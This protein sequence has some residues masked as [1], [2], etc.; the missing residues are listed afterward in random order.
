MVLA[1]TLPLPLAAALLLQAGEFQA[2]V[3]GDPMV[4]TSGN[5]VGWQVVSIEDGRAAFRERG[6][7]RRDPGAVREH[8]AQVGPLYREHG[9]TAFEP[10]VKWMLL[11]PE[12][13][14]WDPTFYDAELAAFKANGLKWVPFLIAGPAYATP[15]WFKDSPESV[16]AVDLETGDVS[17]EQSIWNPRLR[18]R[19]RAWLE[20]FFAHYG[21]E[22]MQAVLLGI[23]GVFGESIYTAGGNA[24]TTIW[25]GDYPQHT[26]WWCGDRYAEADFRRAMRERYESVAALNQAWGTQLTTFDEVRPFA[27]DRSHNDRA[28]LDMVRW[29]M[30]AMTDYAEWWVATARELA[31]A[32]PALLCTGGGADAVLG[33]DMSAQ[34]KMVAR[35]GAGM[36]ITNEA[37]DYATN[38]HIT[39]HISS[40]SRLY[41]TYFG[42]EPAGEVTTDGIV[43]RVYNS[44]AAGAWEFFHYDNPPQDERGE[45]YR[46]YLDLLRV[47]EPVVE[48]GLLWPRTSVDLEVAGGLWPLGGLVR[49][50][51]DVD[52]VDELM[53]GDGAL[54]GL[55]LLVWGAGSVVERETAEGLRAAV[56][57]GLTLLVP[58]G[59][60]PRTPEGEPLFPADL[61][62]SGPTAGYGEF[63]VAEMAEAE[64]PGMP[65]REGK[66][67]GPEPDSMW[68]TLG[69]MCWTA[70]DVRLH[71]PLP[72]GA[73]RVRLPYRVGSLREPA[74]IVVDGQEISSAPANTMAE[75]T[76][77][78]PAGPEGRVLTI[79]VLSGTWV[80]AEAGENDDTR[81]L[82]VVLREVRIEDPVAATPE[83]TDP[84]G[85]LER[86]GQGTVAVAAGA[87][88]RSVAGALGALIASPEQYGVRA[89]SPEAACDHEAD[90]IFVAVTTTDVLLYNQNADAR[91]VTLPSGPV[92]VPAHGIVSVPRA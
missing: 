14:V 18:P 20:R 9:V 34:T 55:K 74:R 86:V 8:W 1:L 83:E 69:S 23:S 26:G 5:D 92:E 33:A 58:R 89:L 60:R 43:A 62:G 88:P 29:Y 48:A 52:Y 66:V 12:E 51:V 42:Y 28:R 32:V 64:G 68:R 81:K 80:P 91:T 11:E 71:V 31:P 40:A 47:R 79:E 3:P 13:G 90:G 49:D 30:G 25:D 57:S 41:D 4:V 87:G 75:A 50:M 65:W 85:H 21:P 16:F 6:E 35:H 84:V 17:R 59:W 77:E 54:E 61:T 76:L 73:C 10:Y 15:A 78:L 45:R 38:F 39:R 70:G 56:E 22:D 2:P 63:P 53:I 67:Y 44:V 19:V 37:S 7:I 24:W 27:P 36:R 46:Q 82:G 72:A